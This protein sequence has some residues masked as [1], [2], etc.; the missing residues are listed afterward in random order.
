MED[1]V[2]DLIA[3]AYADRMSA[4]GPEITQDM[5]NKNIK[6]LEKLLDGYL[7]QKKELKPLPKLLDGNE[8]MQLLNMPASR[9]LGEIV[10][11]LK[12]AQLSSEVVTKD[13]AIAFVTGLKRE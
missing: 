5:I 2:I 10:E 1:E 7:K 6:G 11:K 12:E 4:L 13:D 3:I 9:K 8:I